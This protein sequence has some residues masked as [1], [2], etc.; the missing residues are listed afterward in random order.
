[1]NQEGTPKPAK[2]GAFTPAVT[3][4]RRERQVPR[5]LGRVRG[6]TEP[7]AVRRER[8]A[9]CQTGRKQGWARADSIRRECQDPRRAGRVRGHA[10]TSVLR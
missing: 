6:H 5:L 9:L 4:T 10:G 3:A 8:Y 2:S 7:I 1:M